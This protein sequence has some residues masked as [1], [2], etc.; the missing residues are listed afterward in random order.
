MLSQADN[1]TL[2]RVGSGTAMGTLFR[3]Y[4]IPFFLSKDLVADGQPK[5]VKLLNEDLLV[6]RDTESRVG[7]IANACAHRG[8]PLMFGRNE[9]CGLRCVYHGWKYDVTGAVVDMPAEPARS[10]LKDKVRITAYPCQER[11]GIVW[12]YLGPD[13]DC[14]PALPNMEWNMVPESKVHVSMRIQECNWLQALEGEIDSAH[15]P[16]LH[17]RIDQQGSINDWVAKRDLRPTFEC[18]RQDFGISIAAKRRLSEETLYWRVNQFVLPFYSLVP[19]QSKY[20]E[21]S[22]HA[23]VPMDDENTICLMFSYHPSEPLL[24]RTRQLFTEGHQG[25][26]TG[27]ASRHAY[28]PKSA[29]TPYA[30]YWTKFTADNGFQFDFYS[31]QTTWF[32][33][34]PGLWVQ[35]GACQTGLAAIYDRTQEHLCVSDTGIVMTRR[36]LLDS[37]AALR[38]R[39]I[40]PKGVTDPDTFMVRAIS[41]KLPQGLPWA[42]AGRPFMNAELGA[43]FGYEL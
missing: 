24:T 10:R 3:L 30:D 18:I 40:R 20:P 38:D 16:I 39:G 41:M 33:G 13:R 9:D 35:D 36:L 29:A 34:L 25:R 37:A 42:D 17:A 14:P 31:Q 19:P 5:R 8:A 1:E 23:W 15:A 11:N 2:V 21:L 28:A 27:H 43:G 7:L 6:F 26:E 22:G 12:T 32:S 4:W